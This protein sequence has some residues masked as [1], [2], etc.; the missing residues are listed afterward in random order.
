LPG[1]LQDIP[2]SESPFESE[3]QLQ[4]VVMTPST[5]LSL[6][7]WSWP[8][9]LLMALAT[10]LM[11]RNRWLPA[12]RHQVQATIAIFRTETL[13]SNG[14]GHSPGPDAHHDHEEHHHE[15][16]SGHDDT[17]SLVLSE[18][19]MRNVGLT[20]ESLR[21]V[22]LEIFHKT[23]TV[24]AVITEK[25]GRTRVQVATPMTG[26]IT[27][28]HAVEGEAVQPG[29]LLFRV[30]LTHED[31]V[32][33]QT[34]FVRT[35]GEIDVEKRELARLEQ[36]ANGVIAGKLL[37]DRQYAKRKLTALL[38]AQREA[39]RLHGLSEA[40][41]DQIVKTRRLLSELQMV[42]PSPDS[43][44]NDELKLT[45]RVVQ[46]AGFVSSRGLDANE[47][48][49]ESAAATLILQDLKVHKG[50]SVNA[51]ETLC[52]LTDFSDLYIE[53]MAFE[54]DVDVL[55]QASHN[56]WKVDAVLQQSDSSDDVIEGL[57]IAYM[58]NEIDTESRTLHF[59][60]ELPN[61]VT[62]D[63]G[64]G[65]GEHR[66]VEW[67]HFPGQRLQ[68]RIPVEEWADRI[69]LPVDAVAREGAEFFVFQQNGQQFD[70]VSVHVEYRDQLSVVIANDGALFPGDVVAT[71]G[72]HQMQMALK[73]KTGGAPDPHAG[74]SH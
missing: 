74:H 44:L 9:I 63:R 10:G 12:M 17:T 42:A 54:H 47:T 19:A 68:L 29:A 20:K 70:R 5:I 69:V 52:V 72:A 2:V 24:P 1:P 22:Q 23:I 3:V 55:R 39:L 50:Q 60:V 46:P 56:G 25:P 36:I 13:L 18:Q 58:A 64:G 40:Q 71:R 7:K 16:H 30:R 51:G 62:G 66:F 27:H 26:A 73:N 61:R 37:L 11:T 53:G 34:A 35:L 31:L 38:Q 33:A 8:T 14:H 67:K 32:Q 49:T 4:G 15:A 59:Y 28:I 41:V 65:T 21:P 43:H 57:E 45:K 48:A 6:R